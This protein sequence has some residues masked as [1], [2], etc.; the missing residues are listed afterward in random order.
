MKRKGFTL[1]EL[2]VVVAIIAIL[3]AM[4]LPALSKARERAREAVCMNNLKQMGLAC[5]MYANDYNEYLPGYEYVGAWGTGNYDGGYVEWYI[6]IAPYL[7]NINGGQ[8]RG[9]CGTYL[10]QLPTGNSPYYCP[11]QN[12]HVGWTDYA[13]NI[14]SLSRQGGYG[15]WGAAGMKLSRLTSPSV[16]F[17]FADE[18]LPADYTFSLTIGGSATTQTTIENQLI[19][20]AQRHGGNGSTTGIVNFAFCDGHVSAIPFMSI[21]SWASGTPEGA[22]WVVWSGHPFQIGFWSGNGN[23]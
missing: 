11:S 8:D 13:C 9:I 18:G 23:Y 3:A 2:L 10:N 17:I 14:G 16:T 5:L 6:D 4:L 15:A 12:P 22:A 1:I 7:F 21:P 20:A 19:T